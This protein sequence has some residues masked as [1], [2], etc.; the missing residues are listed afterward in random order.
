MWHC[1]SCTYTPAHN[2]G[3]R[4]LSDKVLVILLT[5]GVPKGYDQD[6]SVRAR[7]KVDLAIQHPK[8]KKLETVVSVEN[9]ATRDIFHSEEGRNSWKLPNITDSGRRLPTW[10]PDYPELHI[11]VSIIIDEVDGVPVSSTRDKSWP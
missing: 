9:A 6:W 7:Y 8:T 1:E 2:L 5:C 3:K 4:S 11:T 10:V